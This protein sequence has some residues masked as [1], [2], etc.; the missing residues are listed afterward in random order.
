MVQILSTI[1]EKR[2]NTRWFFNGQPFNGDNPFGDM[3]PFG[4]MMPNVPQQPRRAQGLGSGFVVDRNGYILTN[5]HVVENATR[6]QVKLPNDRTEYPAKLVGTDPELDLAVLK[7]D[8]GKELTPLH[9][10]NSDAM[11]VG[12]WAVAIGSPFGL[13][14]TM[15]AGIISAKGRDL[16]ERDHQLQRF[17]QTDAAINRGNSGGPLLNIEGQVIGINTM[18]VSGSGNFEG[19]GFA[20]PI[21]LAVNS[22]NQIV[23][24]GKV[25]RG[26]IGIQFAREENASLLKAYGASSGVFVQSV[27]AN[28]PAAKAGMQASDIIVGANGQTMKDGDQLVNMIS[29][30]QPGSTVD[31][32]VLRDGKTMTVPVK[33]GDRAALVADN[34]AGQEGPGGESEG[35]ATHARLGVNIQNLE[36]I[37][38]RADGPEGWRSSDRQRRA[39]FVRRRHRPAEGRC[40]GGDQ[41]PPCRLGRRCAQHHA[42]GQAG[43]SHGVQ[44]DAERRTELEFPFRRRHCAA[45]VILA[46]RAGFGPPFGVFRAAAPPK[47]GASRPVLQWRS[48]HPMK[49]AI[50]SLSCLLSLIPS[51]GAVDLTGLAGISAVASYTSTRDTVTIACGEQSQVRL[52][53]LAPDLIRVRASFHQPLPERDHS[54]AIAKTAWDVPKWNVKEDSGGLLISTDELEVAIHRAPLLIEFRDAG[55]HRAINSDALPMMSAPRANAQGL[56]AVAAAKKIGFDE[57]FYG[58]GEKAAHFDKRR[59]QFSMWNSDTPAYREGTDPIYQDIPFYIGWQHAEAY[60]IFFDNSYRTHFDF[61]AE[62]PGIRGLRSRRRR[63]ELLLLLGALD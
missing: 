30:A 7:I 47:L 56:T 29:A 55:T 35:P 14:Q 17:L 33:I 20:L 27:S 49:N 24:T 31:L 4:N 12:D 3:N 28:G 23:K 13:E 44:A 11:E 51:A 19:I 39:W 1:K 62:S 10:G 60:G 53:I 43:R 26:A 2:A 57:H 37:R 21:N 6:I 5:N 9:I 32:K 48:A 38:P 16:G 46:R 61:A 50:L 52:Y 36:R 45:A 63:N 8:A 40:A 18:I 59:G 22:Y 15:T 41:P 54:W 34:G 58:L 25:S 42:N